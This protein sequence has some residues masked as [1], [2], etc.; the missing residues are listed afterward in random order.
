MVTASPTT[1][2]TTVVHPLVPASSP[3]PSTSF[4]PAPASSATSTAS[5]RAPSPNRSSVR[6]RKPAGAVVVPPPPPHLDPTTYSDLDP[7]HANDE[8]D[9]PPDITR[10]SLRKATRDALGLAGQSSANDHPPSSSRR[11][12]HR[13]T[14]QEREVVVHEVSAQSSNAREDNSLTCSIF[15]NKGAQDGYDRFRDPPIRHHR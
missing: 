13:R 6:S 7:D 8:Q 3:V 14:D 5:S 9:L 4:A 11:T 2:W 12:V 15:P 1:T 10:P